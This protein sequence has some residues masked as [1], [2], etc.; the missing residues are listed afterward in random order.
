MILESFEVLENTHKMGTRIR[1][2]KEYLTT[3]TNQDEEF[4]VGA[5]SAFV[6]KVMSLTNDTRQK[7]SLPYSPRIIQM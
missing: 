7:Y 4:Y 1:S 6:T 3:D 5:M 2:F